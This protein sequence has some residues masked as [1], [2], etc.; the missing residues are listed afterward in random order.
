[1]GK[2]TGQGGTEEYEYRDENG[3]YVYRI[4]IKR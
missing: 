2:L 1:M 3:D 4:V